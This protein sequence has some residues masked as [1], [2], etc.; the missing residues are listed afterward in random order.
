[1]LL[2]LCSLTYFVQAIRSEF[3]K[4]AFLEDVPYSYSVA[5]N[6]PS[7]VVEFFL[8][9]LFKAWV[10]LYHVVAHHRVAVFAILPLLR[11]VSL[12]LECK[13]SDKRQLIEMFR[14][15]TYNFAWTGGLV[16]S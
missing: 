3:V 14:R 11:V 6:A 9:V 8:V 7:V 2:T 12:Q 15:V 1:M 10:V 16:Q 13:I 4:L 5:V